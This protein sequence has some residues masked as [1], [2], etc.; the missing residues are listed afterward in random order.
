MSFSPERFIQV[1]NRQ[2]MTQPIKGTR[3]RSKDAATDL[4]NRKDLESSLKDKAENLMI[5]DLLRN[6]LGRICE[7]GS[8]KVSDLFETQSFTNV[9]HLVSTITGTLAEA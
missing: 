7:T 8:I 3:P 9:H 6:D 5:V 1:K 4:L 2:V